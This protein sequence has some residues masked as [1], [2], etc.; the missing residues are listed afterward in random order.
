MSGTTDIKLLAKIARMYYEEDMTQAA[1]ARKL[2]MSRSLVS[3]LLT[4]ARDKGIVKITICD[5]SNRPYQE[6]ENYLKKIFGL[7]T[8]IVIADTRLLWKQEDI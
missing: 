3:K 2:N 1:I 4:K 6:M 7:S 8:V 5:E